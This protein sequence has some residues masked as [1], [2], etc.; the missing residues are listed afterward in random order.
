MLA[1]LCILV[2]DFGESHSLEGGNVMAD[3]FSGDFFGLIGKPMLWKTQN[4]GTVAVHIAG[5]NPNGRVAQLTIDGGEASTPA[6]RYPELADGIGYSILGNLSK[7]PRKVRNTVRDVA[8]I[9]K[10]AVVTTDPSSIPADEVP[11]PQ[12]KLR[13]GP[14]PQRSKRGEVTF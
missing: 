3:N 9:G 12:T 14:A 2:S 4:Y 7:R 5:I 6:Q 11:V 13:T 1:V 8:G 10:V